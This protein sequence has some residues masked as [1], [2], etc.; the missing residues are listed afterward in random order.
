MTGATR[1]SASFGDAWLVCDLPNIKPRPLRGRIRY[2]KSR[3]IIFISGQHFESKRFSWGKEEVWWGSSIFA[4]D[5]DI[6]L[7]T[8]TYTN[9]LKLSVGLAWS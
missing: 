3:S 4:Q 5:V 6:W 7:L 1:A 8:N 2:I 9:I